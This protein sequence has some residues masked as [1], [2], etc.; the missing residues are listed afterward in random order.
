V[1][2]RNTRFPDIDPHVRKLFLHAEDIKQWRLFIHPEYPYWQKGKACI[3]GDAAHPMTLD[4]N[5]GFS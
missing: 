4:Q 1:L 2:T 5:E 3:L